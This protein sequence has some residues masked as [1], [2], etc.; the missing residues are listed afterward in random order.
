MNIYIGNI[1]KILIYIL[2]KILVK[3]K[4][5]KIHGNTWKKTIKK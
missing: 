1:G 3:R 5:F 2:I 4:L